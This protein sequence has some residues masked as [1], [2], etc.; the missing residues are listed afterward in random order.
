MRRLLVT[1]PFLI[2]FVMIAAGCTSKAP[3]VFTTTNGLIELQFPAGWYENPKDHPFDLQ[4][5]S[6]KR[7][8]STAVFVYFKADFT[9]DSAPRDTLEWQIEDLSSKRENF[10]R[11]EAEQTV[12]L[13]DKTLTT[14]VYSGERDSSKG[15]YRFALV[16]FA[17]TPELFLVVI[18][19]VA[20]SNWAKYKLILEQITKSAHLVKQ[21]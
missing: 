10:K 6:K 3:Q 12:Q 7:E 2:I 8:M 4:C 18:Q 13:K 9:E 17:E 19:T 20:P 15:Y 16:E 21:S 14:I 11:H 5:F 1:V